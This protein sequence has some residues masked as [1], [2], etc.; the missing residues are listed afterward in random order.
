MR[1]GGEVVKYFPRRNFQLYGSYNVQCVKLAYYP[2][3]PLYSACTCESTAHIERRIEPR[4]SEPTPTQKV[5]QIWKIPQEVERLGDH[6][7]R[8]T[9]QQAL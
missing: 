1:A 9:H 2:V 6:D 3:A 4:C 5:C 8:R 7:Q